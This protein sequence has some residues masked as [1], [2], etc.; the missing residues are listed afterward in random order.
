MAKVSTPMKDGGTKQLTWPQSQFN[1]N[2]SSQIKMSFLSCQPRWNNNQQL[3]QTLIASTNWARR[4]E[5]IWEEEG[6]VRENWF[7]SHNQV[8]HW[9][10]EKGG[11]NWLMTDH[12][13]EMRGVVTRFWKERCP[14]KT[15]SHFATRVNTHEW[16][17]HYSWHNH[18]P[19]LI[20]R[21]R[22]KSQYGSP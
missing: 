17:W 15:G 3:I 7:T 18:N 2:K 21:N 20:Q 16:C 1:T 10:E 22:F 8:M 6:G 19:S 9:G 14:V 5:E 4:R 11:G 12:G 13:W